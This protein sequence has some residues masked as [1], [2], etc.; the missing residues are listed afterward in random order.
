M[1]DVHKVTYVQD[2]ITLDNADIIVNTVNC[3]GICG[4]GVA[5]AFKTRW[6]DIMPGY[7]HACS[8]G[9]LTPG[10]CLL[11]PHPDTGT[12]RY[13]AALATKD[14]WRHPSRYEW[15][16][17]GLTILADKARLVGARSIAIPPPGCGNGGLDW[18]LV[19]SIVLASLYDFDLRIYG[20]PE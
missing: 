14:H 12:P 6:P 20:K 9:A 4:K 2:D 1:T 11:F 16:A 18:S 19:R 8:T 15:V 5:L 7:K 10:G 17:S 3:V 13:W